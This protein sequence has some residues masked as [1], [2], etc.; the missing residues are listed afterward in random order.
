MKLYRKKEYATLKGVT[1]QRITNLKEQL[2]TKM[3][4]GVVCVIDC[5]ENDALFMRPAHNRATK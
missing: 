4:L 3:E 2:L 1:P 5:K